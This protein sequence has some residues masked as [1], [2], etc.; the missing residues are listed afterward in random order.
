MRTQKL[1]NLTGDLI[2]LSHYFRSGHVF[3]RQDAAESLVKLSRDFLCAVTFIYPEYPAENW[4]NEEALSHVKASI[5]SLTNSAAALKLREIKLPL[6]KASPFAEMIG[7]EILVK[8][9][10]PIHVRFYDRDVVLKD[11]PSK[12]TTVNRSTILDEGLRGLVPHSY[13]I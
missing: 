2:R 11:F 1:K 12:E 10:F 4:L 3:K 13:N 5:E 6:D 9:N 7:Q 8:N